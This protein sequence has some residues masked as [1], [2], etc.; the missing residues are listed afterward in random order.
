MICTVCREAHTAN[1]LTSIQFERDEFRATVHQIP[2]LVCPACRESYLEE[3]IVA[4]LLKRV[5][6]IMAEGEMD[7]VLEYL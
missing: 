3:G 5:Q 6:Q 1:G 7:I 2:A 4:E